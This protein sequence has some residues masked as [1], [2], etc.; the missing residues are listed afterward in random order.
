MRETPK[1]PD[2]NRDPITGAPGAH[3]IGTGSR[4][5]KTS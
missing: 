4:T 1:R 3:P 2:A 5:S